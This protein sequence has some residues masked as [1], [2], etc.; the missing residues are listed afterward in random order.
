M[1]QQNVLILEEKDVKQIIANITNQPVDNIKLISVGAG[2]SHVTS[3]KE[4]S[5][6]FAFHKAPAAPIEPNQD[7][8]NP[9]V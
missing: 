1:K 6:S 3:N 9:K 2:V 7:D 4:V 5:V 8:I